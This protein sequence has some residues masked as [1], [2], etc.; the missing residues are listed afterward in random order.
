MMCVGLLEKWDFY[1]KNVFR[2]IELKKLANSEPGAKFSVFPKTVSSS[3]GSAVTIGE[4]SSQSFMRWKPLNAYHILK[5]SKEKG[6]SN[7]QRKSIRFKVT[8][9]LMWQELTM[10]LD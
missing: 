4:L 8:R 10:S 3:L 7:Y 9:E 2:K 1:A 6:M 5:F